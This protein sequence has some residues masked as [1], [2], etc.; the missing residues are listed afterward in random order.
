M[1]RGGLEVESLR[2]IQNATDLRSKRLATS[3]YIC[4]QI[5]EALYVGCSKPF[6]SLKVKKARAGL[7]ITHA[8]HR[9]NNPVE[10]DHSTRNLMLHSALQKKPTFFH[11]KHQ[12]GQMTQ[13]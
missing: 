13:S 4:I 12:S 11:D 7:S 3:Q 1:K 8:A 6:S 10:T 9:T 2:R 5:E